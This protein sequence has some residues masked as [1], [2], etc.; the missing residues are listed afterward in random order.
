[1]TTPKALA[2]RLAMWA[3]GTEGSTRTAAL[4]RI[5]LAALLWSRWA[6]D[7]QLFRDLTPATTV[8][9]FVF[10]VSTVAMFVGLCSRSATAVAGATALTMCY[11]AIALG[12]P[13]WVQHNCFLLA[14]ATMLCALTPC[15]RSY[16]LDRWLAVRRALRQQ[17]PLPA[18]R[19]NLWGLRLLAC[20]VSLVYFWSA[21]DKTSLAFLSG[22]RLE[23]IVLWFFFGSTYPTIEGFRPLMLLLASG[24]VVL[25]YALAIGLFL[26]ATRRWLA[27]P[28][29]LLHGV[30]YMLLPMHTF[31]A[32]MW[33]LYLTYFDADAVHEV[34]EKLHGNERE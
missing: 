1:M 34:I 17:R 32:T 12:H 19:G 5:G 22:E 18:E 28:G 31:S 21:Y 14:H 3:V 10:F 8:I 27:V 11:G 4:I 16:S 23:F 15:G 24:T 26:P 6:R 13:Q 25:E 7:L 33:C 2:H 9:A 30:W 29:L 20:Q